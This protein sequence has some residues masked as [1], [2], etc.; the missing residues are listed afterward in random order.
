MARFGLDACRAMSW[1]AHPAAPGTVYLL[2]YSSRTSAGRQH[3][4]GWTADI[5]RRVAQHR[6][7]RGCRETSKAVAEGLKLALAQTWKG[8]PALEERLKAWSRHGRKGF[9][10]ICPFCG[11]PVELPAALARDLGE[12]TLR[13]RYEPPAQS[14]TCD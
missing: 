6:A 11:T 10:G 13:I 5:E 4:V 7:G 2:H 9:A 14:A 3:Y 1:H 8:T 12:P